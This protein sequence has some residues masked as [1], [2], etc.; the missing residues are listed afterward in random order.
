MNNPEEWSMML[1]TMEFM[2]NNQQHADRLNTP[3][4]LM[5]GIMPVAIP[6]AF[7]HMKYPSIEEK[8]NNLIKNQEA[9]AA[10]ELAR[11]CMA[12]RR[13]DTFTPFEKGQKVWLDSC[14]LKNSYHKKVRPK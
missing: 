9:L 8:T 3:F 2:H 1:L 7:E 5:L 11:T 6:L 14:N 12:G 4:G 10:H 13:K